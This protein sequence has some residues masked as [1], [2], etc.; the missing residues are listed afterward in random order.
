MVACSDPGS[1]LEPVPTVTAPPDKSVAATT[2]VATTT[3]ATTTTATT[4]TPST[5][6]SAAAT[7]ATA[8]PVPTAVTTTTLA[9][10]DGPWRVVASIPE[11]VEP[12]LYYELDLPGLYAYFPTKVAVDDQV[13]WTMNE[14]DRPIIEAYLQAQ[15]TINRA[16]VSRPMN[17]DDPGWDLYF[18]DGGVAYQRDVLSVLSDGGAALDMSRGYVLRP[19]IIED[20]RTAIGAIVV[21]CI[22]DGS[23]LR[24]PDGTL[25]PGSVEGW[26]RYGVAVSMSRS[27]GLWRV[28]TISRW[29]DACDDFGPSQ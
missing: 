16:M 11:V 7:T 1:G 10:S 6:V 9:L 28:V 18:E 29:E 8:A 26:A 19:W 27:D 23:V 20:D 17:F 4:A 12:G 5:T 22:S 14:L 2:A 3:T 13:F 25:A 24:R 21:D 15:L